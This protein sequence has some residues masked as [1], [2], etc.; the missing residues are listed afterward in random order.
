MEPSSA[1]SSTN[2]YPA[3]GSSTD[4]LERM[5]T[6]KGFVQREVYGAEI[7]GYRWLVRSSR[8]TKSSD[9]L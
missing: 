8:D 2:G 4:E 7:A 5:L 9:G 1:S 6:S 3:A